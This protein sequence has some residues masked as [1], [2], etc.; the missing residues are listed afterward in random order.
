M[1]KEVSH[2][3]DATGNVPANAREGDFHPLLA[4]L[5]ADT[6]RTFLDELARVAR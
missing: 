6:L 3:F 1:V 5:L 2:L 4:N